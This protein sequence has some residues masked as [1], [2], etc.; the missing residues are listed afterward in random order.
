V[1]PWFENPVDA[2]E[3]IRQTAQGITTGEVDPYWGANHIWN[4]ALGKLNDVGPLRPFIDAGDRLDHPDRLSP[5][6]V[7]EL[8]SSVVEAAHTLLANERFWRQFD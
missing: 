6:E 1:P 3:W 2:L 5:D 7:R 8:H 4:T